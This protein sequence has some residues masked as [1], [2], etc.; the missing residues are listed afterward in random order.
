MRTWISNMLI[1]TKTLI[2]THILKENG[3]LYSTTSL[4]LFYSLYDLHLLFF[5]KWTCTLSYIIQCAPIFDRVQPAHN[6][7]TLKRC[8]FLYI[9][10]P[11]PLVFNDRYKPYILFPFQTDQGSYFPHR[12]NPIFPPIPTSLSLSLKI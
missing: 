7:P 5:L 2:N 3:Y 10:H 11:L 1:M 4:S 12:L 9:L 8:R 6:V